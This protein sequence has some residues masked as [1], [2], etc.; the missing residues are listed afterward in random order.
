MRENLTKLED[1]LKDFKNQPPHMFSVQNTPNSHLG[2]PTADLSRQKKANS[3][4]MVG[5]T[6]LQFRIFVK[7]IVLILKVPLDG[8]LMVGYNSLRDACIYGRG[9]NSVDALNASV[10]AIMDFFYGP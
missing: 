10:G 6:L 8:N 7:V 4:R 2:S 5:Y 1:I 9:G 3:E